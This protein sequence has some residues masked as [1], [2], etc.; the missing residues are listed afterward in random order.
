MLKNFKNPTLTIGILKT[1]LDHSFGAYGT[2]PVTLEGES[3]RSSSHTT[4]EPIDFEYKLPLEL[5][6]GYTGKIARNLKVSID[7][8]YEAY[9]QIDTDLRDGWKI[10]GGLAYEP[11]LDSG[12]K[13]WKTL[14]LRAGLAYRA[15]PFST[16]PDAFVSEYSVSAGVSLPLK[17]DINRVDIALQYLNRGDIDTNKLNDNS[18]MLMFGFTG[19][20][21]ISKAFNRTAP[22]EIPA[23]EEL[24]RW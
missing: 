18:L 15:L 16:S 9:Q 5:G 14:P 6:F 11:K 20:D 4:E 22:R 23:A 24:D 3:T 8:N 21:V 2:L 17:G 19:F 1:Y 10:G 7:G 12:K 13:W